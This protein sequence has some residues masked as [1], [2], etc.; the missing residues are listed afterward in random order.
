MVT[1]RIEKAYKAFGSLRDAIFI[2]LAMSANYKWNTVKAAVLSIL[3][4]GA[5]TWTI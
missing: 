1:C 3:L 5:G 2:F 4:Y